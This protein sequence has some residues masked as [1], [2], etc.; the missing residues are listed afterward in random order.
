M[1]EIPIEDSI[2]LHTFQPKEIHIVVTEYLYQAIRRGFREVR[3]IHGR[4]IGVQRDI[5]HKLLSGNSGVISF[6]DSPDRGS[7]YVTLKVKVDAKV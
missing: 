6:R 7:T 4:G 3:I 2:D 5:V 1:H